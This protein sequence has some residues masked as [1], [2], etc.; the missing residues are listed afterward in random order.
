MLFVLFEMSD[1][2]ISCSGEEKKKEEKKEEKK[3]RQCSGLFTQ[4]V[5]I[6]SPAS[7]L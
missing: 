7:I 5:Y 1:T 6:V 2:K 4:I 3:E